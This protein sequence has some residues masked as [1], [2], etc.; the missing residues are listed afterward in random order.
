MPDQPI[1]ARPKR[2]RTGEWGC[3]VAQSIGPDEPVRI[4]TASGTSW[5]ARI[6]QVIWQSH[7]GCLCSTRDMPPSDRARPAT[8][9]ADRELAQTTAPA[10]PF[11]AVSERHA[12]QEG[13]RQ[14][15]HE[16]ANARF[17]ESALR[18]SDDF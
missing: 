4:V 1:P 16:R 2:L 14:M 18:F 7:R 8:P 3:W 15:R 17:L 9:Y 11:D 5:L 13:R 10:P 6:E 12:D